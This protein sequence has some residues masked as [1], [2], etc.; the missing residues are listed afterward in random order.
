MAHRSHVRI[1]EAAEVPEMGACRR[2]TMG[3]LAPDAVPA[4]YAAASLV[5]QTRLRVRGTDR[6]RA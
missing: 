3:V 2:T 5:E 4:L 6:M 1:L